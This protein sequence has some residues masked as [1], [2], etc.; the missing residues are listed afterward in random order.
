MRRNLLIKFKKDDINET[1][2][3]NPKL[4]ENFLNM[5]ALLCLSKNYLTPLRQKL[6]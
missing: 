6:K 3:L 4:Q 5:V 2:V 1:L